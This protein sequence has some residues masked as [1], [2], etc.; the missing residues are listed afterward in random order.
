MA[1]V[2]STQRMLKEG[3]E[4]FR[5]DTLGDEAFWSDALQLHRAIAGANLTTTASSART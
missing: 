5:F 4:T 3:K 1:Q 2:I